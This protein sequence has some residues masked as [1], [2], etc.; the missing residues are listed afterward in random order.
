MNSGTEHMTKCD[1]LLALSFLMVLALGCADRGPTN[2]Y[3]QPI[4]GRPQA[5]A[6][7]QVGGYQ[8]TA[9]TVSPTAGLDGYQVWLNNI[10]NGGTVG[11]ITVTFATAVSSCASTVN[12]GA[13]VATAIFGQAGQIINPGDRLE[14][15]AAN[16]SGAIQNYQYSCVVSFVSRC[17]SSRVVFNVVATDTHGGTWSSNFTGTDQ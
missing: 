3:S 10:G 9:L 1:T 15:F 13:S 11:P 14:G 4:F 12:Y 5:G 2:L 17:A 8:E 16:G 6:N 7:L